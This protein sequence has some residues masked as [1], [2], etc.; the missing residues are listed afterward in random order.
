MLP[1]SQVAE[2]GVWNLGC[3][4]LKQPDDTQLDG[5]NGKVKP[6]QRLRR[7]SV[8]AQIMQEQRHIARPA[9]HHGGRAQRVFQ[10]QVPAN[11]PRHLL[12]ARGRGIGIGAS[13]AGNERGKLGAAQAHERAGNAPQD[14]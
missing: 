1:K 10:N 13:G 11:N 6:V 5:D 2:I 3:R 14:K 4:R 9:D 12:P 8:N 7:G